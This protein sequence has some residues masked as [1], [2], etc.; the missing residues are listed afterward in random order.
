MDLLGL[1]VAAGHARELFRAVSG[2]KLP[3]WA[4]DEESFLTHFGAS[5]DEYLEI[6]ARLS[7]DQSRMLGETLAVNPEAAVLWV[8]AMEEVE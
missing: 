1:A 5:Y 6:V 8:L 7:P 2:E 3:G 4:T